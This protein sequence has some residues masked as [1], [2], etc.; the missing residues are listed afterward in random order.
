MASPKA[1]VRRHY[2]R[3]RTVDD[4][5]VTWILVTVEVSRSAAVFDLDQ[6]QPLALP[7]PDNWI[8]FQI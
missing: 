4:Q 7:T 2:L 6:A 3:L 8:I 5:D 1:S